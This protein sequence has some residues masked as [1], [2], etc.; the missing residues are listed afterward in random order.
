MARSSCVTVASTDATPS[1]CPAISGS[2]YAGC[3]RNFAS[4]SRMVRAS[5]YRTEP[6]RVPADQD[7]L[8]VRQPHTIGVRRTHPRAVRLQV[9]TRD[10]RIEREIE[11]V[12]DVLHRDG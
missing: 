5:L 6:L 2:R 10:R 9:P 7:V 4:T 11:D 12:A 3:T 8:V 1:A